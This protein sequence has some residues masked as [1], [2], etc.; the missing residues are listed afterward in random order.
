VFIKLAGTSG[1][2]KTTTVR[3]VMDKFVM[4]P[5]LFDGTEKIA[6]Y[7]TLLGQPTEPFQQIVVLGGYANVCGGL[8]TISDKNVRLDLI[9]Q[10]TGAKK[11]LVL[12]EGL[13]ISCYGEIGDVSEASNVPWIYAFMDTP[14]EVCLARCESRR[15]ARG[16]TEPMNPENTT[17]KYRA[18]Q[19]LRNRVVADGV[20]AVYDVNHT[21][22]PKKAAAKL[23][24]FAGKLYGEKYGR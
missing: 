15:K 20:H 3:A 10:Y 5:K 21:D 12:L 13:I 6:E 4:G 19:S 16:V 9:K 14:L 24:K 22:E 1:S 7:R 8:D 17:A 11:K 18:V 23:L 2:G